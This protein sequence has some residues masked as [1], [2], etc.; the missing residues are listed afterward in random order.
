M[1]MV[2]K[3]MVQSFRFRMIHANR[4]PATMAGIRINDKA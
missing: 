2:A 1:I 3:G 4:M